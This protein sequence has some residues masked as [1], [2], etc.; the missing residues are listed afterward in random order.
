MSRRV[1]EGGL[2]PVGAFEGV[3]FLVFDL[4]RF[5]CWGIDGWWDGGR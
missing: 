4:F 1:E 3:G 2:N 5:S